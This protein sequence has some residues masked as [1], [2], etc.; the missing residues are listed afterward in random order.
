VLH[1]WNYSSKFDEIWGLVSAAEVFER[2]SARIGLQTAEYQI[3][4]HHLTKIQP[5]VEGIHHI[6]HEDLQF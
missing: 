3:E 4:L 5:S 2:I 6:S 1:F